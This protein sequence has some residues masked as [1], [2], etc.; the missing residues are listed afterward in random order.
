MKEKVLHIARGPFYRGILLSA[1]IKGEKVAFPLCLSFGHIP[2]DF[3]D[4]E[5]CFSIM[6]YYHG[7]DSKRWKEE[8][9]V[10]KRLVK[11]DYSAYDKVVVWHGGGAEELLM[12]YMMAALTDNNLYHVDVRDC[13]EYLAKDTTITNPDMSYLSTAD[14][15]DFN[16]FSYLKPVSL[17][18]REL[19]R[20]LWGKWS[21]N[22]APYRFST[23]DSDC[24]KEY[25][26]DF[27][28]ETILEVIE[29]ET[30]QR[31]IIGSVMDRFMMK[32]KRIPAAVIHNRIMELVQDGKLNRSVLLSVNRKEW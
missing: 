8:F 26:S 22:D 23:L 29:G 16:M 4:K 10:L 21:Q 24:I 6:S 2:R 18:E 13:P 25:S 17:Q 19:Y 9:S 31:R 28:D 5:L 30:D 1:G 12:F 14:I 11:Q 7:W 20:D 15:K 3:S 32:Y 27:M